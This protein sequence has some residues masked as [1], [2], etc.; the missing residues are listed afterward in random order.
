MNVRMNLNRSMSFRR[1]LGNR[2]LL[3]ISTTAGPFLETAAR[4]ASSITF[5]QLL[6]V[7]YTFVVYSDTVVHWVLVQFLE[8]SMFNSLTGRD[9]R[10]ARNGVLSIAAS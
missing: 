9:P 6:S 8:A 10:I 2:S 5:W 4:Q 7:S 1:F 3:G